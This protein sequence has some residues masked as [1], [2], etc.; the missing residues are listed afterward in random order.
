[1]CHDPIPFED[2]VNKSSAPQNVHPWVSNRT[3]PINKLMK[4]PCI[5]IVAATRPNISSTF[6]VT[7][8][9]F[10]CHD[11]KNSKLEVEDSGNWVIEGDEAIW[12][13]YSS[14]QGCANT[15]C[16]NIGTSLLCKINKFHICFVFILRHTPSHLFRFT[17]WLSHSADFTWCLLRCFHPRYSNEPLQSSINTLDANKSICQVIILVSG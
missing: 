17:I 3:L 15:F 14:L 1:M 4:L 16:A 7:L 2:S 13:Y 5:L 10:F 11:S 12:V 8:K 9:V 6:N